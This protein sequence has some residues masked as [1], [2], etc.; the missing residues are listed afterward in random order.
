M[1]FFTISCH[2]FE[3]RK[4]RIKT[5]IL[6]LYYCLY[7]LHVWFEF[8]HFQL[9][10]T[11][12]LSRLDLAGNDVVSLSATH[13]QKLRLSFQLETPHGRVFKPHQVC[14]CFLKPCE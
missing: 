4:H 8:V 10:P 3:L 2:A 6:M 11:I 5:Y 13:L 14:S 1:I 9:S 7:L 12:F